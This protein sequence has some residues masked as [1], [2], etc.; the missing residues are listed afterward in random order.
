[1]KLHVIL[2]GGPYDGEMMSVGKVGGEW[3]AEFRIAT[4]GHDGADVV[5]AHFY[6]QHGVDEKGVIFMGSY[7]FTHTVEC[8]RTL[9]DFWI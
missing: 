2:H 7:K 5:E 4:P 1:M 8:K 3:P 6:R 9:V